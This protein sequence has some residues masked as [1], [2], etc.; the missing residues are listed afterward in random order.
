MAAATKP[1][2]VAWTTISDFDASSVNKYF[3]GQGGAFFGTITGDLPTTEGTSFTEYINWQGAG[4]VLQ[5]ST[6]YAGE[7]ASTENTNDE[8][9]K[10]IA[11]N[12]TAGTIAFQM[13][14]LSTSEDAIVKYLK[15]SKGSTAVGLGS[16]AGT[17]NYAGFGSQVP[18][19]NTIFGIISSDGQRMMVIPNA[20]VSGELID[21]PSGSNMLKV[22]LTITALSHD[23][24]MANGSKEP[25][26]LL[27]R[28]S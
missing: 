25:V 28:A 26:Y 12:T 24:P 18:E 19:F 17:F 6:S 13:T 4:R 11:T 15:G 27:N 9:G 8:Q 1:T 14:M 5:D 10:V 3:K 20:S 16:I 23:L 21:A 22:Q 7:A 2:G